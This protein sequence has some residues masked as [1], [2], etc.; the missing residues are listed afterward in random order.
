MKESMIQH[1]KRFSELNIPM[2]PVHSDKKVPLWEGW[3]DKGVIDH[4]SIQ[5]WLVAYPDCNY[6]LLTGHGLVVLDIDVKNGKDGFTSLASIVKGDIPDTLIVKTPSGGYHYYFTA[7]E[8]LAGKRPAA[9][10]DIQGL[11]QFV[12]GPGS[13]I[14]GKAYEIVLDRPIQP[15]PD[16]LLELMR[17]EKPL[18]QTD[19]HWDMPPVNAV[20]LD[21]SL[22]E[23]IRDQLS[24]IDPDLG[25]DDWLAALYAVFNVWGF[26]D[27]TVTLVKDWSA[28]GMKYEEDVFWE[29][30]ESYDPKHRQKVGLP[31]LKR[32]AMNWPWHAVELPFAPG[33]EDLEQRVYDE[34]VGLMAKHNNS[35][36][37]DHG[38]AL[39]RI[40]KA[41]T[42]GVY[43]TE[44]KFR[45]AFP[46]ETGMGKTTAVL[47]LAKVL[48]DTDRSLLIAAER[49]EQ[50]SELQED[51]LKEG[52]SPAK[53]GIYHQS[54]DKHPLVSSVEL[55]KLDKV[56]FLLVSHNKVKADS[57]RDFSK[58]LNV[59]QG[60]K[61]DLVIWDESLM[62][63]NGYAISRSLAIRAAEDW[64]RAYQLRLEENR[65]SL[66]MGEVYQELDRF[67]GAVVDSLTVREGTVSFPTLTTGI[68]EMA[69]YRQAINN[70]GIPPPYG[71]TLETLVEFSRRGEIR[72]LDVVKEGPGLIQFVQTIDDDLDQMVVLDASA[73][74][75]ELLSYDKSV[76]VYP[77]KAVK[78]YSQVTLHWGDARSSKLS[79]DED[80]SHLQ[81][82][83]KEVDLIFALRIPQGHPVLVFTHKDLKDRIRQHLVES[84]PFHPIHVLHW[85][86]HRASNRY[87]HVRY[88][89]TVGVLY[90]DNH[91]LA[92]NIIGQ[93]RRLDYPLI[94]RE[95]RQVQL[96]EQA[97]LLYQGISR[98]NSRNTVE[99]KAG[100]QDIFL[101]HPKKDAKPILELLE[102]IM[103][104]VVVQ[105]YPLTYLQRPPH[106]N[107]K[108]YR[109]VSSK[110]REYLT[111][112]DEGVTRLSV[113]ELRDRIFP[114]LDSN[115]STWKRAL[116]H[117]LDHLVGWR[118][119]KQS[120]ERCPVQL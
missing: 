112:L 73:R 56:Q 64:R 69:D 16:W 91:E 42:H 90:R 79:F 81:G 54:M 37:D 100:Q 2:V 17:Q 109:D 84:H 26:S 106:G 27:D 55:D 23:S 31:T 83:L 97:D 44:K 118:K 72:V 29:K 66:T 77:L 70:L 103:P 78:D 28:Q 18:H 21:N 41:M 113:R 87:A 104:G 120:I 114:M 25:Y 107:A 10:V 88:V 86:E 22:K 96:S 3:P 46:L 35:L 14:D 34:H 68:G 32:L 40:C 30:V 62:A 82:Y 108:H 45:I 19:N 89:I 8:G 47:A 116:K 15:M 110:I 13:T 5:G 12:M 75:R 102:E 93:T 33:A 74:I 53:V 111:D 59:Y 11:G 24:R 117:A 71:Q 50:L 92:A 119:D 99:G 7:S 48:Q 1:A 76:D 60:R 63:S 115:T 43:N 57:V 38:Q 52:I 61:R 6:G 20:S 39:R 98:G 101:F 4:D 94:D 67:L 105:D 65:R 95:V 49:I 58:R 9:G 36:S 80:G 51:M 85:G